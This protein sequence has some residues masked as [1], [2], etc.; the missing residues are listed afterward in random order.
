MGKSTGRMRAYTRKIFLACLDRQRLT[1]VEIL[2]NASTWSS[3]PVIR[4]GGSADDPLP[5]EKYGAQIQLISELD[6]QQFGEPKLRL[7]YL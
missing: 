7:Y 4:F 3:D 1:T 5:I 2:Q 6:K